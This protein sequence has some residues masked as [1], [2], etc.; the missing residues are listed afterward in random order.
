M[1][2]FNSPLFISW[3]CRASVEH[4]SAFLPMHFLTNLLTL[5]VT[6]TTTVL[7]H[8]HAFLEGLQPAHTWDAL[9]SE[10]LTSRLVSC[11]NFSPY[12]DLSFRF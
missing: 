9:E 8:I 7:G 11:I 2:L 4:W 5:Q 10:I 3:W 6:V 12:Y 1:L